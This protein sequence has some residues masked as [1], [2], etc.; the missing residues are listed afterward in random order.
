MSRRSAAAI[1]HSHRR[2]PMPDELDLQGQRRPVDSDLGFHSDKADKQGP[3]WRE[4]ALQ[5]MAQQD[6]KRLAMLQEAVS[7]LLHKG[8]SGNMNREGNINDHLYV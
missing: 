4:V 3:A 1:D 7:S 2:G 8:Q 6:H 5:C